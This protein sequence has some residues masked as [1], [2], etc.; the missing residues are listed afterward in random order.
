MPTN[1]W[2]AFCPSILEIKENWIG[3]WSFGQKRINIVIIIKFSHSKQVALT[4]ETK[5]C[6]IN[7]FFF[8]FNYYYYFGG[9]WILLMTKKFWKHIGSSK[10]IRYPS[11]DFFAPV[12]S[13]GR[14]VIPPPVAYNCCVSVFP[15]NARIDPTTQLICDFVIKMIYLNLLSEYSV[16]RVRTVLAVQRMQS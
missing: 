7:L 6:S 2:W 14:G 10:L 11:W 13:T 12:N 16:R 9:G 3:R 15:S 1:Y 4:S 8:F 5:L